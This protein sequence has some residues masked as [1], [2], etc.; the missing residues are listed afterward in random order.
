MKYLVVMALIAF[1]MFANAQKVCESQESSCELKNQDVNTPVPKALKD[2]EI[3]VTLPDGTTQKYSANE[4]KVVKRQQQFKVTEKVVKVKTLCPTCVSKE[5]TVEVIKEVQKPQKLNTLMLG[6]RYDFVNLNSEITTNKITLYS[7]RAVV[8]DLTYY[9]RRLFDSSIGA[10]IG[11]DS[12]GTPR[13][14][15][16]FEF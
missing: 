9:R 5:I 16:G 11:I 13:G 14:T 15:V 8:L 10:G 6:A 2:A 12:N 3:V 1:P 4:F 7:N